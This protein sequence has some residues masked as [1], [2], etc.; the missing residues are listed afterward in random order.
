MDKPTRLL[1]S[2]FNALVLV[3]HGNT[4][5]APRD[6]DR[7]LSDKGRR[8]RPR[9]HDGVAAQRGTRLPHTA[10]DPL[11]GQALWGND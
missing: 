4:S 5:Q 8:S 7:P 11:L 3:R 6:F 1:L 10:R 9:P 2:R